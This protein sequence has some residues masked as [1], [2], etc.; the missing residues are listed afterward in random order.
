MALVRHFINGQDAGQPDRT[1]PVYNPATGRQ[2]HELIYAS[3][4]DVEAAIA[5]AKDAFPAWRSTSLTKRADVFFRLRHLLKERGDELAAI[6]TSEHGKVL[7][8]AAGEV[9][10]GL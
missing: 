8:D 4:A 7:S 1:G 9:A 5:A 6:V 2:Q 3:V 10:R